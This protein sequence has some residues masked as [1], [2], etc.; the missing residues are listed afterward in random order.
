[1]PPLFANDDLLRMPW[2]S[3]GFHPTPVRFR[4]RRLI[5]PHRD[6]VKLGGDI[7]PVSP[8]TISA[9]RVSSLARLVSELP[10]PVMPRQDSAASEILPAG[11]TSQTGISQE[12]AIQIQV[13]LE[14]YGYLTGSPTGSWDSASVAA[15][16]RL[17]SD[18]HWQTRFMPDARALIFLG[19]GPGK[20]A[21]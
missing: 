7:H 9:D 4:S 5:S 1:M 19:L 20:E 3:F 13:A 6:L 2:S 10:L 8:S 11:P 15:M 21:L 17:Q 16:R 12:R 14:R 18:H